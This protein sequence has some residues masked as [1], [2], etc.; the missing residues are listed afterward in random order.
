VSG[1]EA[2]DEPPSRALRA[3]ASYPF[4]DEAVLPWSHVDTRLST[5]QVYWLCTVRPGVER[6][7]HATPLWGSWV[8]RTLYLAGPPTTRWARN[9]AAHPAVTVHLE[10][11]ENVVILEGVAEDVTT[12]AGLGRRIVD[13]WLGKYGRLAPDPAGD[14]IWRIRPRT[15]R[16]WSSDALDDATG[17]T[18]DREV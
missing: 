13:D 8:D 3:P 12:D 5:A 16:A 10:S 7:P 4:P 15:V 14:G 6:P 17:W 2:T 18:L 11:G 1:T 9:L